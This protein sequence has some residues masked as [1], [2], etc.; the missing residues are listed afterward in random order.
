MRRRTLK[1]WLVAI[2]VQQEGR[3]V[4]TDTDHTADVQPGLG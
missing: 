4:H 2:G 3:V 1:P